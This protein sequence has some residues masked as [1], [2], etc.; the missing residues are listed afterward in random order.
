MLI[1]D[2]HRRW[3][4]AN[5]AACELFGVTLD[6]TAW[7]TLDEFTPPAE[8]ARLAQ[9]W[10]TL[11]AHEAAEGWIHVNLPDGETLP[12]EFSTTA[13]VV[14][15]R[16]L[17]ILMPPDGSSSEESAQSLLRGATGRLAV[18]SSGERPRLTG[19][20]REVM[21]LVASGLQSG[22]IAERLFVSTETVKSHVH[23]AM[24]KLAA[25]TR[26][27]AVTIALVTGQI[28]WDE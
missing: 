2:D 18:T 14:P 6:E 4:T 25:H 16:H 12:V 7:H 22:E 1:V 8:H 13:N 20:E 19:R 27:H 28:A 24:T 11:L 5:T 3:V 15:G 17:T 23:N 10:N 9:V 26:A 21:T